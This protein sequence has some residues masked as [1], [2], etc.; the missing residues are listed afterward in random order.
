MC[1]YSGGG[2][3]IQ[4]LAQCSHFSYNYDLIIILYS[5]LSD[6]PRFQ[7]DLSP[8]SIF[9]AKHHGSYSHR[10]YY[11]ALCEISEHIIIKDVNL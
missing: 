1:D 7:T 2:H 3:G 8:N 5:D 4:Q 6:I 9:Q 10:P 11:M